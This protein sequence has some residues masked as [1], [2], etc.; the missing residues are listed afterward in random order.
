ML[1]PRGDPSTDVRLEPAHRAQ[2][3]LHGRWKVA[4]LDVLVERAAGEARAL[5]DLPAAEDGRLH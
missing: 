3:E 5:L 4:V 2:A 1:H